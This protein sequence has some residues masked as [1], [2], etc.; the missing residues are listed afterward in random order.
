MPRGKRAYRLGSF[1]G[2]VEPSVV[3]RGLPTAFLR[4][5][6][7]GTLAGDL[8]VTEQGEVIGQKY[9]TVATATYNLELLL[10]GT[11]WSSLPYVA[12]ER[13]R[14]GLARC[15]NSFPK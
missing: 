15:L 3:E 11:A 13:R 2:G 7:Q 9:G 6:P 10:A 8:R 1:T 4:R 12:A 5:L 14:W